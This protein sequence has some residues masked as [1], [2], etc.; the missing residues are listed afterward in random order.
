MEQIE[1]LLDYLALYQ[2]TINL[3]MFENDELRSKR[4]KE[5]SKKIDDFRNLVTSG[6]NLSN[7]D[8]RT[9]K[10]DIAFLFHGDAPIDFKN[11][12]EN[13]DLLFGKTSGILDE[14]NK[15]KKEGQ[16]FSF[17]C[18]TMGDFTSYYDRY[19][20][21]NSN[22]VPN[23]HDYY[24]SYYEQR[25]F[26]FQD[27][28]ANKVDFIFNGIPSTTKEYEF[29]KNCYQKKMANLEYRIKVLNN[30]ITLLKKKEIA[31]KKNWDYTISTENL[32]REYQEILANLNYKINNLQSQRYGIYL[33]KQN[34][35]TILQPIINSRFSDW[36]NTSRNYI[37]SYNQMCDTYN[38]SVNT[39]D[40]KVLEK[41]RKR[42]KFMYDFIEKNYSNPKETFLA[43]GREVT[44]EDQEFQTI[45]EEEREIA[46]NLESMQRKAY[47]FQ[48]KKEKEL[49]KIKKELNLK[50]SYEHLKIMLK[51]R[52]LRE[53]VD[54][55]SLSLV[56]VSAKSKKLV[57]IYG[58]IFD[59]KKKKH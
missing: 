33:E 58:D 53:K 37:N 22:S 13:P 35:M 17:K 31:H 21:H 16:A 56:K 59:D 40:S 42:I 18:D 14:L 32:E 6:E 2:E 34:R 23:N 19:E 52:I 46:K 5:L 4:S 3:G 24:N 12:I 28:C 30:N 51:L 1:E 45:E 26:S 15:L 7:I 25:S 50:C 36:L 20:P 8:Y 44:S 49:N 57:N 47:I 55:L 29:L 27:F 11:I 38:R 9:F 10:R 41:Q 54:K 48:L 43:I 39:D